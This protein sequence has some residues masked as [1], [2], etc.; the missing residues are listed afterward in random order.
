MNDSI[1]RIERKKEE[2]TIHYCTF[3]TPEMPHM[4]EFYDTYMIIAL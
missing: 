1:N 3:S 2:Y 4:N